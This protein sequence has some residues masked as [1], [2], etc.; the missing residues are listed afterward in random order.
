MVLMMS[1]KEIKEK[2]LPLLRKYEVKKASLFGSIVRD[3]ANEESDID[4]LLEL[5]KKASLLDLA[6]LK[7]EL[8]ETIGKKVDLVEYCTIKPSLKEFILKEQVGIL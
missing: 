7:V 8:E 4:I 6:G 5:P 3:E 2:I 1:I